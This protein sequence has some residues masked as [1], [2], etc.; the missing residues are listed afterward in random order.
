MKKYCIVVLT[1]LEND[2][3]SRGSSMLAAYDSREEALKALRQIDPEEFMLD[4]LDRN[5]RFFHGVEVMKQELQYVHREL[6][7]PEHPCIRIKYEFEM[8]R[9]DKEPFHTCKRQY[10]TIVEALFE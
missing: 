1:A 6:D 5:F 3:V 10:I 8:T 2:N 4:Q 7:D 9:E